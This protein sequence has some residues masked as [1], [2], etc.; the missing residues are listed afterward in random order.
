MLENNIILDPLKS[1]IQFYNVD[2]CD[3]KRLDLI[4]NTYNFSF[5]FHFASLTSVKDSIKNPKKFE[6]NNILSTKNLIRLANKFGV[7]KFIFSSSAAV[8]GNVK[9]TDSIKEDVKYRP[10]NAYGKSKLSCE[11][12]LLK[13]KLKYCIFRYFNVVGKHLDKS[14]QKK[15]NFNLFEKLAYCIKYKLYLYIHGKNHNTK[16]GTPIRDYIHIDDIV[17]AHLECINNR[18][19]VFWNNIYNIGY[20]SGFTVMEIVNACNRL[21]S[22][23]IRV[24]YVERNKGIITKSIANNNKLIQNSNWKPKKYSINKFVRYFFLK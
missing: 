22:K 23:K 16:D 6:L 5:I 11:K 1:K 2:C 8:Y 24:K 10:I 21:L 4:F 12:Y 9:F 17:S 14:I 3:K 20:N 13:S 18:K 15:K 19:N 7:E